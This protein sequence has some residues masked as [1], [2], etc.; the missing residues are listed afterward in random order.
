VYFLRPASG[1]YTF[2]NLHAL[3]VER[4]LCAWVR[5]DAVADVEALSDADALADACASLRRMF[6]D[7][8]VQPSAHVV[9]RWASDPFSYGSYSYVPPTGSVADYDRLAVPVSG[10]DVADEAAGRALRPAGGATTPAT[11]LFF[12]GEATHRA[13]AYTVH[14]AFMSGA[15]EAAKIKAWWRDHADAIA[16]A[17]SADASGAVTTAAAGPVAE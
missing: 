13:D 11:R 16:A 14:G 8:F 17:G 12:A 15:R 3:G 1:R 7:G 5:P 9:T 10:D 4:V 6:P 2:A